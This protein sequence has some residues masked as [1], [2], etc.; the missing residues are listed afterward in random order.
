MNEDDNQLFEG[1]MA[2]VLGG[3]NA[4]DVRQKRNLKDHQYGRQH[5]NLGADKVGDVIGQELDVEFDEDI[6]DNLQNR[7]G[8]GSAGSG[9]SSEAEPMA[10]HQQN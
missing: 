6:Q 4:M 8:R 7:Q 3:G 1:P 10:H 2:D 9:G 5:K